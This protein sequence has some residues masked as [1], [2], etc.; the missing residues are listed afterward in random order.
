M[1]AA[2]LFL[3]CRR[4]GFLS[5]MGVSQA[6]GDLCSSVWGRWWFVLILMVKTFFLVSMCRWMNRTGE[7]W[8]TLNCTIWLEVDSMVAV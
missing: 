5:V 8:R 3:D 1:F 6:L 4:R 2:L 7:K